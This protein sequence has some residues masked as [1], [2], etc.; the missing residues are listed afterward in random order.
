VGHRGAAGE[1]LENTLASFRRA[2][3]EGADMVELD[4]QLTGDR[5]LAAVH[6]LDLRRLARRRIVVE[7]AALAELQAERLDETDEEAR[8][9]E[10]GAVLEALPPDFPVNIEIKRWSASRPLLAEAVA[11]AIAGRANVLISSFDWELLAEIQRRAPDRPLAPLAE[12]DAPGLLA[13]GR[14]LGAWSLHCHRRLASRELA[15]AA[16]DAGRPLLAYTVND[17][18]EARRL[19]AMG[20]SGLFTD[21]PGKMRRALAGEGRDGAGGGAPLRP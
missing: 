3:D 7:R 4:V 17:P 18:A 16:R 5:R 2:V 12:G 8:I 11:S 1:R 20:L 21:V 13:A 6:D 19:L 9:P 14:E 15:A 10:L